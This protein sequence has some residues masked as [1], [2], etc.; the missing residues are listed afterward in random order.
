[1]CMLPLVVCGGMQNQESHGEVTHGER[2][3]V[4]VVGRDGMGGVRR[5]LRPYRTVYLSMSSLA[6]S[7]AIKMA[8][9]TLGFGH[10]VYR[11]SFRLQIRATVDRRD[12]VATSRCDLT[13]A[14]IPS[15]RPAT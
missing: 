2:T 4:L 1:M 3:G 10:A 5:V 7:L 13:L 14:K 11:L 9:Q 6:G 12:L 15:A 8:R